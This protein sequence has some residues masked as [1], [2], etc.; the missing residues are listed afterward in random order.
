M[1]WSVDFTACS[2]NGLL[3]EWLMQKKGYAFLPDSPLFKL[4]IVTLNAIEV[5]RMS[6][7]LHTDSHCVQ[8]WKFGAVHGRSGIF[9]V[10]FVQ[11]VAAPDFI[12][13][14]VDRKEEPKNK[15]GRVAASAA[16]AVAV[17]SAMAAHELDRTT[18]VLSH[19]LPQPIPLNC[20]PPERECLM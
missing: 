5:E 6:V 19:V 18:E 9:P 3:Y 17:G 14:P 8:G 11:P 12:S 7:L 20:T 2:G 15:Q 13:L 10:E 16:V 4:V 1:F